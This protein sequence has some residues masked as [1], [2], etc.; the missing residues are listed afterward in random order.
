MVTLSDAGGGEEVGRS[1]RR[2]LDGSFWRRLARMGSSRGPEWFVRVAPPIIGLAACAVAPD[3]RRAIARNLRRV[4]GPRG[5]IRDA[6]DV[7]RTF[8][9]YAS[10]LAEV[11]GAG[12]PRSRL[13]E[14][15]V[16][17]ELHLEDAL[18][19]RHGVVF[20]TAHTAGWE[21]VGALL[22]RDR[23]LRLMIA[24]APERDKAARAIQDDA[25]RAHGVLVAHVGEDPLAA[26]PL[27]RHLRDGGVVALQ[28]DRIPLGVRSR[29]VIAFGER[30]RVPEGPL[31]L[32]A[33]TGAPIVPIFAARTG[34]RRYAVFMSPPIRV[35]R[36]AAD[37]DLD[38]AAQCMADA[39]QDF[40][41]AHATQWFHFV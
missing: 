4:R 26:L 28:I 11:L 30:A 24:E 17:G 15:V 14:V 6:V 5:A 3:E 19:D 20:A 12:S 23:G 18:A 10:C 37:S 16:W 31:R 41:R 8:A 13:P 25:R 36:T 39:M 9:T 32:A 21:T 35:A 1:G 22:S 27:A 40:V 2:S 34:H 29:K 38:E 33:L 7:G